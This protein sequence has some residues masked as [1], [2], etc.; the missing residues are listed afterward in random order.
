MCSLLQPT[1]T[2]SS[3]VSA[4]IPSYL[5]VLLNLTVVSCPDPTWRIFQAGS[6][7]KTSIQLLVVYLREGEVLPPPPSLIISSPHPSIPPSAQFSLPTSP[8]SLVLMT[9]PTLMSLSQP[10]RTGSQTF[11]P[12]TV[13]DS[14]ER[15]SPLSDS[16][17]QDTTPQLTLSSLTGVQI[18]VRV[19]HS[20]RI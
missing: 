16:P 19:N 7:L 17:S 2:T 13:E 9:P 6:G 8:P 20:H 15:V 1:G 11:L 5:G 4:R 3:V 18:R 12:E 10:R 14:W